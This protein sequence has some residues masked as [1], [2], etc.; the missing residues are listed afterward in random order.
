[1]SG[2]GRKG[3]YVLAT[4]MALILG[5]LI[6]FLFVVH[7]PETPETD[8]A[9]RRPE[10]SNSAMP[11]S[12]RL[13]A[14]RAALASD[15][16]DLCGYGR[17]KRSVVEDLQVKARVAGDKALSRFAAGLAASKN[18]SD[19]ALGLFLQ[20][21]LS[22]KSLDELAECGKTESC[23]QGTTAPSVRQAA[24]IQG[25]LV[26]LASASQNPQAYALAFQSCGYR[27]G[28]GAEGSCALLSAERWA[29]IEPDN[30][31]PWLLLASTAQA[32]N[33]FA[34]RDTAVVRASA[35]RRFDAHLPNFLGLLQSPQIQAETPQIRAALAEDLLGLETTRPA[36]PYSAFL[37][38]CNY[39]STADTG[40]LRV[41]SDLAD[42]LLNHDQTLIGLGTGLKLG[43]SA[44]FPPERLNV[45]REE[46]K[47]LD[48]AAQKQAQE[49]G[50]GVTCQEITRFEQWAAD[51]AQLGDRGVATKF[52][53]KNGLATSHPLK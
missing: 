2:N 49:T 11:A 44:S 40:R 26:R 46:K 42:L 41:C 21:S 10:A 48:L 16:A 52:L 47:A 3:L 8:S 31:V 23:G 43:Q 37:R 19:S 4:T 5:G 20:E 51:Y 28:P 22:G 35:A 29:Q 6:Y 7:P 39:P 12:A 25:S 13:L 9:S 17:V 15:E 38:F 32:A 24:A 53:E 50:E 27:T 45:L 33:D 14:A 30:G 34:G 18:E 36:M 1:M